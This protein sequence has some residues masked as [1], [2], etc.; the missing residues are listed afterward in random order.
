MEIA[1][2][3]LQDHLIDLKAEMA[4][5][6]PKGE[7]SKQVEFLKK[8][9]QNQLEAISE[10]EQAISLLKESSTPSDSETSQT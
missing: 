10:I 5:P 2:L 8:A 1:I 3:L 6:W 7:N 9:K 4:K